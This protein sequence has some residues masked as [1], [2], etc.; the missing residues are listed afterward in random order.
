MVEHIS[1]TQILCPQFVHFTLM[2][3]ENDWAGQCWYDQ[4]PKKWSWNNTRKLI[5]IILQF[6]FSGKNRIIYHCWYS[7][8]GIVLSMCIR[9]TCDRFDPWYKMSCMAWILKLSSTFVNGVYNKW[10]IAIK[11][12]RAPIWKLFNYVL[13]PCKNVLINKRMKLFC[14]VIFILIV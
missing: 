3:H 13:D 12:T 9:F 6:G 2:Q 14:F 4:W 11:K 10:T 8:S 1:F 7:V 5:V